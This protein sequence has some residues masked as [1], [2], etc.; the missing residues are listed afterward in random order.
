MPVNVEQQ[1]GDVLYQRELYRGLTRLHWDLR[2]AAV[3]SLLGNGDKYVVDLGCGE[4][5]TLQR[6][7]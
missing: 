6:M 3:L 2:D 5:I 4:G 7:I 1:S